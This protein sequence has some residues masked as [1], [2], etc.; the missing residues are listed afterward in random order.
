L[1]YY[2]WG[3]ENGFIELLHAGVAEL[4]DALDLKITISFPVR[5]DIELVHPILDTQIAAN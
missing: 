1:N 2:I 5:R 4:A 3:L